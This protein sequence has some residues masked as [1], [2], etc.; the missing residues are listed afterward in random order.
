MLSFPHPLLRKEL[1][2]L[3]LAWDFFPSRF[4]T[5]MCI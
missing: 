3:R 1:A 4:K 2:V 5:K